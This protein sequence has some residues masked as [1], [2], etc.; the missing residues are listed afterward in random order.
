MGSSA[1]SEDIIKLAK[2]ATIYR[3]I[4]ASYMSLCLIAAWGGSKDDETRSEVK[5][6][7]EDCLEDFSCTK[8]VVPM[9]ELEV[10]FDAAAQ[11]GFCDP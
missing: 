8:V 2:E 11:R 1:W 9:A 10:I 5:K 6:N 4:A 7:L 3:P